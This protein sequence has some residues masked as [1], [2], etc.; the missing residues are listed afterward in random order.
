MKIEFEQEYLRE[1]FEEGKTSGKKYRFQP[2]VIRQ[3]QK[4]ISRVR[5]A[6]KIEDLYLIGSLNYEKL[7]GDKKGLNLCV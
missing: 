3:F 6:G 2:Q 1:L 7:G 5:D 4:T